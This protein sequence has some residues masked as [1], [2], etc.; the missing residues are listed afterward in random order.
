MRPRRAAADDDQHGGQRPPTAS[1]V[2]ELDH[3]AATTSTAPSPTMM[4]L[5]GTREMSTKPVTTVPTMAPAVPIA[6]SLPT[7]VPVSLRLVSRSLVTIGVTAARIVPGTMIANV[8]DEHQQYAAI[9]R[10]GRAHGERS[11]RHC[12]PGHRQQRTERPARRH[13]VGHPTP[14]P[15]AHGDGS[16]RNADDQ[17]ARLQGEPEVRR[18]QPQ[19]HH[20]DD[21]H[22]G[23]GT[24]DQ[25]RR[26]VPTKLGESGSTTAVS[27]D[28]LLIAGLPATLAPL[29]E[30]R[31]FGAER[32][33][34]T[35]AGM[36]HGGVVKAV[37]DLAFK[38]IHQGSEVLWSCW[39]CPGPPGNRLSPVN[40]CVMPV[41]A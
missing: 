26:G 10:A 14:G 27:P 12:H 18:Q 30:L 40:R 2:P 32:G 15:G 23:R 13:Q 29:R 35:V 8:D 21:K 36:H 9:E 11:C 19:R 20:L 17:G 31:S 24:E 5:T 1:R 28:L 22:A 7:T 16:Q 4:P 33:V 41:S 39:S 38:I 6:E 25:C 37:E 3:A 34:V